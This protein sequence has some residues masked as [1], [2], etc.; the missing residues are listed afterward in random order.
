MQLPRDSDMQAAWAG[1]AV[2]DWQAPGRLQ[3][4]DLV[5]WAGHVGIL[6]APDT[7]LHANVHQLCVAREPLA[8]AI[9]RIRPVAGDV[10]CVRR[11]TLTHG[12]VPEWLGAD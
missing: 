7:L 6:T 2:A 11:A 10:T 5:F 9:A 4:G 1:E 8:D 3:R 12:Q